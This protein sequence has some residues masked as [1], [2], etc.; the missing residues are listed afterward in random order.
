TRGKHPGYELLKFMLDE[1]HARGIEFHPWI[2]PYRIAPRAGSHLSYPALHRSIQQ[3]RVV[4]RDT[5]QINNPALTEV[6]QRLSDIVKDLV[7]K[8]DVDGL[9]MDDY[10][11]PDPSSAGTMKSDDEDFNRLKGNFTDKNAWRRDNVDK[12]IE[13]I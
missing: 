12:A 1:A 7:T 6:A 4:D 10:F 11:Y 3:S 8:Y 9:H 5:I 13:L 2:N